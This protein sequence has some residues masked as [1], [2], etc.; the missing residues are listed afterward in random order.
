MQNSKTIVSAFGIPIL[1]YVL[2]ELQSLIL[3][4][5]ASLIL[6]VIHG[7]LQLF[8]PLWHR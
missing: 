7:N 2:M 1:Y 8:P 4:G 6:S 5:L 3:L